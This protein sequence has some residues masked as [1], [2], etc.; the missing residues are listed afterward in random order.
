MEST[1]D[2][3]TKLAYQNR[4]RTLAKNP[5]L[6]VIALFASFVSYILIYNLSLTILASAASNMATNKVS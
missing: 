5:K 6:I 1:V 4:W 2:E 3:R